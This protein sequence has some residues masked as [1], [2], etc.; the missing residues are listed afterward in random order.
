M[1]KKDLMLK[2]SVGV[3][4]AGYRRELILRFKRLGKNDYKVGKRIG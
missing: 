2:N 1:S 4:D 3:L